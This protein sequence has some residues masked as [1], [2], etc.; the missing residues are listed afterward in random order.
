MLTTAQAAENLIDCIGLTTERDLQAQ[1]DLI[2]QAQLVARG[3]SQLRAMLRV[4]RTRLKASQKSSS[5][6][7]LTRA[8]I[9]DLSDR[10]H[11][12]LQAGTEQTDPGSR[13][14]AQGNLEHMIRHL[15]FF[16][17]HHE[18]GQKL[19]G[20]DPE[21]QI[22]LQLLHDTGKAKMPKELQ[23]AL[24]K[25][26]P[27]TLPD[28]TQKNQFLNQRILSHEFASMYWTVRL[29]HEA[30]LSQRQIRVLID[31]ISNHNFGFDLNAQENANLREHFWPTA[32]RTFAEQINKT[33]GKGK[34]LVDPIYGNTLDRGPDSVWLGIADRAT[35]HDIIAYS[36]Y[37]NET[38]SRGSAFGIETV[39]QVFR[40]SIKNSQEQLPAMSRMLAKILTPAGRQH[41]RLSPTASLEECTLQIESRVDLIRQDRALIEQASNALADLENAQKESWLKAHA[42]PRSSRFNLDR[43][44]YYKSRSGERYLITEIRPRNSTEGEPLALVY[45]WGEQQGWTEVQSGP[46]TWTL[47][48]RD[49]WLPDLGV[50]NGRFKSPRELLPL[51]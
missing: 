23:A 14:L 38:I 15:E 42:P 12:L 37:V 6:I 34:T 1:T 27:S 16:E 25:I 8:Q 21:I 41:L 20:V 9:L 17:A 46:D 31:K 43:M 10:A 28:G 51:E 11:Q 47:F 26:F 29:G 5:K 13:A 40:F 48:S 3:E 33:L 50:K 44:I 32:W 19:F 4:L 36:K 39:S 30:G 24:E 35:G 7:G 2:N 45:R 22:L 18:Q 49:L